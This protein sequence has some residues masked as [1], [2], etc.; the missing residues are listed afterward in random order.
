MIG[1]AETVAITSA[2]WAEPIKCT[3]GLA[4]TARTVNDAGRAEE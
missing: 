4:R 3:K 1:E 2:V